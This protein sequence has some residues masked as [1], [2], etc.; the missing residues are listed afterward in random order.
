[1]GD[2]PP[3]TRGDRIHHWIAWHLPHQL[4]TWCLARVAAT[5]AVAHPHT[6]PEDLTLEQLAGTWHASKAKDRGEPASDQ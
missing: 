1:M 6:A 2:W 4:V 3:Q 5:T